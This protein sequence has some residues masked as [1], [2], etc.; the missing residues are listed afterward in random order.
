ML[1]VGHWRALVER[2]ETLSMLLD[3]EGRL[4]AVSS[5]MAEILDYSVDEMIG[6]QALELV[7]PDD[8]ERTQMNWMERRTEGTDSIGLENRWRRKRGSE[9]W[10]SWYAT[11]EQPSGHVYAVAS[12]MTDR[13]RRDLLLRETESVASTG[14]WELDLSANELYWTEETYRLHDTSPAEYTP[15]V[16]TALQFYTDESRARLSTALDLLTEYG[17]PFDEEFELLTAKGR[18]IQCRAKGQAVV[19]DGEVVGV[20]GVF[21]DISEEAKVAQALRESEELRRSILRDMRAGLV[22]QRP[23]GTIFLSNQAA[24]D[25]L[26]LTEDQITG[27]TSMDKNWYS[28]HEDGSPFPGEAH[29]AMVSLRT[30]ESVTGAIMGVYRPRT[31]DRVWILIDS[32]VQRDKEG[33][34]LRVLTSFIDITD[35]KRAEDAARASDA[36]F[37]AVYQNAGLGVLLRDAQTHKIECNPTFERMIGRSSEALGSLTM[38]DL[39]HPEDSTS[40]AE[41]EADLLAGR[42]DSYELERRFNHASGKQLWGHETVSLV[43]G[44]EGAPRYLVE[45]IVDITER[46]R[47]ETQLMLADRMASLGTMAAGVGHEINNPLTWIIGN[48]TLS[49][50]LLREVEPPAEDESLGEVRSALEEALMGASRVRTIVRDLRLFSR[51]DDKPGV[52]ADLNQVVESTSRMLYNEIKHRTE[53][54]LE[55][56]P[57]PHVMGDAPRIGQILTNLLVNALHALPDRPL[58]E[59]LIRVSTQYQDGDV[60]LAVSDN[61]VGISPALQSRIFDPFFTTKGI[62]SGTGLGLSICHSLVT[63]LGGRI[64]LQSEPG[65]GSV[66]RVF[67]VPAAREEQ[68]TRPQ[69]VT[70]G[71]S[72]RKRILCIDDEPSVGRLIARVFR[73]AHDVVVETDCEQA[74]ERLRRGEHYDA[75]ICDLMMPVMSGIEFFDQLK[76]LDSALAKR[77]GFMT[78]GVFTDRVRSFA[79]ALPPTHLVRKPFRPNAIQALVDNLIA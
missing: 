26:G 40:P 46:K 65:H 6:M 7:H 21:Q 33:T 27:R 25:I 52:T 20:Y 29:P 8:R 15:D 10:L 2:D 35:R 78:G 23:D 49:L 19:Q 45:M 76:V 24:L 74:I 31:Q 48:I 60:I 22:A 58:R 34:I 38:S 56:A 50:E 39:I 41:A 59:N 70:R 11:G 73:K 18:R 71:S 55:L 68:P 43:R 44:P 75:I 14:G 61:G 30:G 13:K 47:M 3:G 77:C 72:E 57:G 5:K 42:V 36:M 64:E 51:V 79:D 12:D 4:V 32:V 16:A 54:R 9:R 62:G 28:I 66:F 37:R 63:R 69:R 1:L 17:T 53:F 67:L